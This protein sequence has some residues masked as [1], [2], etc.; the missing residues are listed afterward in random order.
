MRV[1][2]LKR[3]VLVAGVAA[4]AVSATPAQSKR[5]SKQYTI[6]QFM[7]TVSV[8]G[9]S[10]SA[11]ESRI[12]FSSN[13]TGIWN[14]YTIPVA[15]G[16]WTPITS[17]TT[18]TTVA[19]RYFPNDDRILFTR[20][21]GGNELNHLYVRT[22]DGQEKDL[23]P[24]EKLKAI[25]AGFA[26]DGS[27]F[28]VQS[29]KRDQRFFDI[30]RYDAKTYEPVL[31]Y[32]NDGYF[33]GPVSDDG[34]WLALVKVMTTTNTDIY[35][36]NTET[37]V[38]K[39]LT[40]HTG[41]AQFSPSTFDRES[42]YLYYTSND[43]SE[44]TRL[45]RYDLAAGTHEDVEKSNWDV[46][47][48]AFSR[49]GK[50]RVITTNEDGRLAVKVSET[51][52]GKRLE[53]P[54][55]PSGGVTNVVFAR[56]DT[57]LAF[58]LNADRSPSD[59]YSL[60]IGAPKGGQAH[61]RVES[62]DR[63]QRSRRYAGRALQ[64]ARRDDDSEHSVEAAPGDGHQQGAGNCVGAWRARR[65]DR[66]QLQPAGSVPRQQRLRRPWDQQSRQLGLR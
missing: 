12:L 49:T 65:P 22:P 56:S 28:Y 20:D 9:A 46:L 52:S 14:A 2:Q 54:S 21:Q 45:R 42:N 62:R 32:Q 66:F 23:T 43:G 7:N 50:Y 11:D 36:W 8:M 1:S 18:D 44:F 6:E 53:L 35:L 37:K 55:L 17:S 61:E 57:H 60:K 48:A 58:Y 33:L 47:D 38:T 5:P 63:F 64:G 25:F 10:F 16:G 34:K 15:G 30:Y 13:K 4:L 26:P 27:V 59:L 29:N 31:F 40:A 51:A 3:A 41:D 19:V 39:H 24:G